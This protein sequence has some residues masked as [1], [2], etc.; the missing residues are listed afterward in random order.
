[1]TCS[2]SIAMVI[3]KLQQRPCAFQYIFGI[4]SQVFQ[5]DI[6]WRGGAEAIET[7]YIAFWPNVT[8]PALSHAG[9]DR[10]ASGDRWRQNFVA[11]VLRLLFKQFNARHRYDSG[12]YAGLLQLLTPFE[13]KP[14]FG[15]G[16]NQDKFRIS[17]FAAAPGVD[18]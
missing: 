12:G 14:H 7:D 10:Q 11:I 4:E 6:T 1:M 15:A 5:C 13:G 9:L 18:F 17:P 8:I 2:N 3:Q 16:G